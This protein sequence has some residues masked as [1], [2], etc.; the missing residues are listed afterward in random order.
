MYNP[1]P[2]LLTADE[3]FAELNGCALSDQDITAMAKTTFWGSYPDR[4]TKIIKRTSLWELDKDHIFNIIV[5]QNQ[6]DFRTRYLLMW[7]YKNKS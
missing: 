5:T 7:V 3:Q 6:L 4:A 2:L 1:V